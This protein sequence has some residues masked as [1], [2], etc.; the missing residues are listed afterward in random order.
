MNFVFCAA[1]TGVALTLPFVLCYSAT[2]STFD[3]AHIGNIMYSSKWY[4]YPPSV[5]T[6][7]VLIMAR[8][9]IPVFFTGLKL[10]SCDLE[11]FMRVCNHVFSKYC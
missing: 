1:S 11:T 6:H 4:E 10:I 7:L 3:I 8:S 5:R 9:Q 2:S